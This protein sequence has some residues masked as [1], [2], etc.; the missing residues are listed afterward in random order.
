[1]ITIGIA[2][3]ILSLAITT[4]NRYNEFVAKSG[5]SQRDFCTKE[6]KVGNDVGKAVQVKGKQHKCQNGI[7]C[8]YYDLYDHGVYSGGESE[9]SW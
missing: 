5:K 3:T 4:Q 1:M 8:G 9:Y 6:R 7:R 2:A